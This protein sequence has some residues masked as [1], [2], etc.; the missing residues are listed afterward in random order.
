MVQSRYKNGQTYIYQN[1][2]GLKP[3]EGKKT[4]ATHNNIGKHSEKSN[5]EE[6]SKICQDTKTWRYYKDRASSTDSIEK[7]VYYI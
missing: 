2:N 1:K 7:I 6:I 5:V 4:R 3:S